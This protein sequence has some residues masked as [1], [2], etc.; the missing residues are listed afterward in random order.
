MFA[1]RLALLTCFSKSSA[2]SSTVTY[3]SNLRS[4]RTER[5]ENPDT[6]P[7]QSDLNHA[8]DHS[9]TY[10]CVLQYCE[11]VRYRTE[12]LRIWPR[13]PCLFTQ[14]DEWFSWNPYRVSSYSTEKAG[15]STTRTKPY[16]HVQC[17][18]LC[19]YNPLAPSANHNSKQVVLVVC[20][21]LCTETK[22][23]QMNNTNSEITKSHN[24][25]NNAPAC[26]I[27]GDQHG[28][29][30]SFKPLHR[31]ESIHLAYRRVQRNGCER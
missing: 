5:Q 27:R 10:G 24:A 7:C 25:C 4:K 22:M 17:D 19:G 29:C 14:K 2:S 26:N 8:E 16:Q 30:T 28:S 6:E 1:V 18:P 20:P 31:T 13:L 23:I 15:I 12:S 21:N 11:R 9:G 3:S